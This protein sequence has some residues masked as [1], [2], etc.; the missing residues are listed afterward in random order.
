VAGGGLTW[1]VRPNVQL[2]VYG[3]GGL[4]QSSTDLAA[5]CGVSV[6]FP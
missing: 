5:G 4:T 3:L 2:D 6:H 1:M